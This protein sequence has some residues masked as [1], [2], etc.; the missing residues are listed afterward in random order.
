MR[1][2]AQAAHLRPSAA[3]P[4][5]P[6]TPLRSKIARLVVGIVIATV[7]VWAYRGAEIRFGELITDRANM[8]E[9]LR[10]FMRP[11]FLDLRAYMTEMLVTIQVALWGTVLALFA[12]VPLSMLAASNVTPWWVRTPLRRA[13]DALRSINEMVF[14]MIFISAVGLG[15][16]AGVLAVFLHNL[17][18]L[19]K[20]FSEAIEAIEPGPVEGVRAIGASVLEEISYGVLPQVLPH[21]IS[22]SLYRFE[23]NVRSAT[24]VGIVGAGGIGMLL[25]DAIRSFDYA[26]TSAILLVIIAAVSLLDIGS[27]WLRRRF[28]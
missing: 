8:V 13:M 2:A 26:R 15:P 4:E 10:G 20:L 23:S 5:P 7:L 9:Y 28:I 11:D 3:V 17:G 27:A 16:F 18:V 24:V 14:A 6:A 22:C 12:A 21:W 25:W 1:H 19:T